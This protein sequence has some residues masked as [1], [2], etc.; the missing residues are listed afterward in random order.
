LKIE[1]K[2][3]VLRS[4][5]RADAINLKTLFSSPDVVRYIPPGPPLTLELAEQMV[6]RRAKLEEQRGF[7]PLVIHSRDSG[8]FLG[9][10][11]LLA[12]AETTDAEI[13]YHFMPA[14]WGKGYASEAGQA[15]LEFGF[16]TAGLDQIVGVA[17]PENVASWKVLEKIGMD[18]QGIATYHGIDGLRKYVAYR[19]KWSPPT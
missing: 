13:A 12:G 2:R 7:A 9:S 18:F 6:E 14:A 3:L 10:G 17:Y 11:G 5:T 15:I 4:A 8:D 19:A 16:R 1:T